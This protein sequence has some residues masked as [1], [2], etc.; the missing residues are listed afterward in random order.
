MTA[1]GNDSPDPNLGR[2]IKRPGPDRASPTTDSPGRPGLGQ[3]G[4]P[5]HEY[6]GQRPEDPS[7]RR[8]ERTPDKSG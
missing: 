5:P 8:P 3:G 2:T 1:K 7:V 4:Q 6:P